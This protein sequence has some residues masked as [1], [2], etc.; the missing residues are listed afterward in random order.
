MS[1]ITNTI[2][3][4]FSLFTWISFSILLL[5]AL[6][7]L[8]SNISVLNG[9]HSYLVLSG[10]MEPSILIGDVVVV[11]KQSSYNV[12]DI[13][14]FNSPEAGRIVTHRIVQAEPSSPGQPPFITRGDANRDDDE[15]QISDSDIIG[16][17]VFTIP[18]IGFLISFS[19]SIPGFI[20]LIIVPALGIIFDEIIKIATLRRKNVK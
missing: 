7:T 6:Y 19:R 15:A 10:S 5:L 9:Y 13:V 18:K 2:S 16:K 14:T 20:L 3:K 1:S 17:V 11:H 8:T 12:H 4:I